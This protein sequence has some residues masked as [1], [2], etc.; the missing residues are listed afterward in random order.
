MKHT[1]RTNI[2]AI[3]MATVLLLT[4]VPA[5]AATTETI[6]AVYANW[7]A[8]AEQAPETAGAAAEAATADMLKQIAELVDADPQAIAAVDF[9]GEDWSVPALALTKLIAT[10]LEPSAAPNTAFDA[11]ATIAAHYGPA[12]KR[13]AK[14]D[15]VKTLQTALLARDAGSL[16]R[17]GADGSY[18]AEGESA[19]KAFQEAVGLP[20]TGACDWA[21]LAL[22]TADADA[23]PVYTLMSAT[24]KALDD[25]RGI[26]TVTTTLWIADADALYGSDPAKA[27]LDIAY[28]V[29][30][31]LVPSENPQKAVK[32]PEKPVEA[33]ESPTAAPTGEAPEKPTQAPTAAPTA[34]PTPAPTQ[35]AHKWVD[36]TETVTVPE[37]GHWETVHYEA[38]THT[39]TIQHPEEG[40]YETVKHDAV[41]HTE[42]V[43][44]DE[45]GHWETVEVPAVTHTEQKW[46]VDK[47]AWTEQKFKSYVSCNGCGKRFDSWAAYE[48]H[49]LAMADGTHEGAKHSS[50]SSIEVVDSTIEHPEEGHSETVTVTDSPATTTQK[51]VVDKAAWTETVTVTDTAAWEEQVWKVDK[52]AW[53]ETKTVVD[54]AAHDEQVWVVDKAAT[55]KTVV[56]GQRCELCGET[57]G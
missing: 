41:T 44:H 34:A 19:V 39:E 53:T 13:G 30:V 54:A 8:A 15:T 21:T 32:A 28:A 33:P 46:V 48:A 10:T 3:L 40:H 29:A 37:E 2:I 16:P 27:K 55:T 31:L 57:Q 50:W 17:Y 52:A 45:Q 14:G 47:K 36:V 4:A 7:Q 26:E 22:L 18:G 56:T 24:A 42:T 35:H 1:I 20:A 12:V 49:M 23:D 51:W 38:G 25:G 6:E 11:W 5:L 9:T 43:K